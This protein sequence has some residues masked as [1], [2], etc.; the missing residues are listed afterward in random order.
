VTDDIFTLEEVAERF[1]FTPR[2]LREIIKRYR[3]DVLKDG[4]DIRFDAQSIVRL[5]EAIR[6]PC[7]SGSSGRK[8][9]GSL[10]FDFY[11]NGQRIRRRAQSDN[12]KLA[13]E[14]A[15][16]LEADLLRTDWH[17]ERRGTRSFAA[18]VTAYIEAKNRSKGTEKRLNRLLRAIGP[19]VRLS[20]IDQDTVT[21]IKKT[22]LRPGFKEATAYVD[23][24]SPLRAV[25]NMA[26]RRGWCDVPHFE[27]PKKVPGRTLFLLPDQAERLIAAAAPHLKP[28]VIFL[29]GTG[30]RM[31]EA[32]YLSW[33][34]NSVDLAGGRVIF[35]ADRTKAKKR[36]V[37][38]MPPRVVAGLANLQHRDGPVFRHNGGKAYVE[39]QGQRG[40]Q[41]Q[42]GFGTAVTRAGLNPELTPHCCRHTWATWHYALHKDPLR[43]RYDGGWS[44]LELV[45]RYAHLMPAGHEAA[46]REF[47]GIGHDVVTA[48]FPSITNL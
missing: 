32:I 5:T 21:R 11:V 36:R 16:A 31:S 10:S 38:E 13:K 17:G 35:W 33:D 6:T 46:I 12:P 20:E 34:D 26:H 28:L 25:L 45:E 14:E 39:Q 7:Q 3:I 19:G 37:A 15:A 24:I 8:D 9:T 30:A 27:I 23:I 41:I 22:M 42:F 29:I 48:V 4:R 40:G 2:R 43:L 47:L 18:A 1:H 44:T